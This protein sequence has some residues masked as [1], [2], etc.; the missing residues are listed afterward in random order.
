MFLFAVLDS[1]WFFDNDL[2]LS[3]FVLCKCGLLFLIDKMI[4]ME[5]KILNLIINF[6]INLSST[7]EL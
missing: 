5:E 1:E 2:S 6:A 7:I 4:H 3:F